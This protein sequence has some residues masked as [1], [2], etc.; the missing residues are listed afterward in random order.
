LKSKLLKYEILIWINVWECMWMF[1]LSP[2]NYSSNWWSNSVSISSFWCTATFRNSLKIP[3]KMRHF[4]WVLLTIKHK[5][6]CWLPQ[7]NCFPIHTSPLHSRSRLWCKRPYTTVRW[8][9]AGF[10]SLLLCRYKHLIWELNRNTCDR[11]D[12]FDLYLSSATIKANYRLIK[13]L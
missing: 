9:R 13:L 6:D 3:L 11:S 1:T 4:Y 7:H 8:F 12:R 10:E 2:P 5:L